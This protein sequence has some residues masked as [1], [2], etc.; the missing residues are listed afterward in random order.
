MRV[1]AA[2]SE[3]DAFFP[4][5]HICHGFVQSVLFERSQVKGR[6]QLLELNYNSANMWFLAILTRRW[7]AGAGDEHSRRNVDHCIAFQKQHVEAFVVLVFRY[8]VEYSGMSRKL[9]TLLSWP[10]C[11][12]L[13]QNMVVTMVS[14]STEMRDFSAQPALT[15]FELFW[16][17]S[18]CLSVLSSF[19]QQQSCG[20]QVM[21]SRRNDPQMTHLNFSVL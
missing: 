3:E 17:E 6:E 21:V 20:F 11:S 10:C 15:A 14:I 2:L 8:I 7:L 16:E 13:S 18:F 5:L 1:M 19:S 9:W 4:L 12:Q